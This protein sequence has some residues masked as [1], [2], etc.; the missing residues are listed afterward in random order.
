[1]RAKFLHF[2]DCHLGYQQYGSKLRFDDFSRAFIRIINI[3]IDQKVDFV[4]LA[5]DLFQKRAIDALTLNSAM[6]G[7]EKLAQAR[8][9]CIA[10]EGNHEL[11]YYNEAIGW[12][13]FLAERELLILLHPDFENGKPI[14]SPYERRQGAYFD[15]VPGLRVFGM[16]YMGSST[17]AA[18]AGMAS[19]IAEQPKD[20]VEYKICIAHTGVEGV[21]SGHKGGLTHGELATMRPHVDYLA[22]GHVHKP[23]TFDDWVFNAGS[24]ETCSMEEVAWD[25]RGYYLV[26][27]DT[28]RRQNGDAAHVATLRANPRRPFYRISVKA[29]LAASPVDLYNHCHSVV[30]RRAADLGIDAAGDPTNGPVVELR[31]T[32][33]LPFD[34]S[35]LNLEPIKTLVEETF[36]PLICQVKNATQSADFAVDADQQLDR[37]HLEEQIVEELLGRDVRFRAQSATWTNL[38]LNLKQL[39]LSGA[40]ADTILEELAARMRVADDGPPTTADDTDQDLSE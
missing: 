34:R 17:H 15:P 39:A 27:V 38:A 12:L 29:D 20:G 3:A 25:D 19:A 32:G 1:M 30:K 35:G 10:V 9:P 6:R 21:L 8:I 14:L 7:L 4:V 31:L 37:R 23:F 24:P 18:F 2:S 13:R 5:G 40:D 26:E 33:V 36:S 16:R 22:L 28:S 11:A